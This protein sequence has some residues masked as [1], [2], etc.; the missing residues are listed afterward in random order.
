MWSKGYQYQIDALLELRKTPHWDKLHFIWVGTGFMVEKF[1]TMIKMFRMDDRV[2]IIGARQ[3]V[4]DLLD[5][6]DVFVHPSQFEGMPLAVMEAM[7]KGLPVIA[8]AVSGTPEAIHDSGFLL[9]DPIWGPIAPVL[10]RTISWL[11]ES[12]QLRKE[13]GESAHK[14]AEQYFRLDTMVNNYLTLVAALVARR[15]RQ[16]LAHG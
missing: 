3:D 4:P 9:P 10:G 6:A 15:K 5:S 13:T 8:T 7:A 11:A 14:R 16:L 12:E 2:H 1:T